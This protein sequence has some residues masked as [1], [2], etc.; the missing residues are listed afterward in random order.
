MKY[1]KASFYTIIVITLIVQQV[2]I[3]FLMDRIEY[4][5]IWNRGF[6]KQLDR[7][8]D[9]CNEDSKSLWNSISDLDEKLWGIIRANNLVEKE[10]ETKDPFGD[11]IEDDEEVGN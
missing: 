3:Y 4:V 1:V 5:P 6:E 10:K 8:A 9:K 2:Q 7:N 11:P